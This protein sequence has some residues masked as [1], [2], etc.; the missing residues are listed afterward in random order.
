M[1][2]KLPSQSSIDAT[3]IREK[4]ALCV[5]SFAFQRSFAV[6][7]GCFLESTLG[8]K[9]CFAKCKFFLTWNCL[10]GS[11]KKILACKTY[12]QNANFSLIC[13]TSNRSLKVVPKHPQKSVPHSE[14]GSR[15]RASPSSCSDGNNDGHWCQ[16]H[17]YSWPWHVQRTG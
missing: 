15:W 13:T 8:C 6:E 14:A 1:T 11:C 12:L 4:F 2:L 16:E 17:L 3:Q 7:Y 10:V 5:T 9:T